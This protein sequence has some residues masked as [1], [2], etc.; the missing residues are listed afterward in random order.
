MGSNSIGQSN[1]TTPT[2]TFPA[3]GLYTVQLIASSHSTCSDTSEVQVTI[4]EPL[5]MSISHTDSLCIDYTFDFFATVSGPSNATY[6]W[7]FG[8]HANP[9]TSSDLSVQGLSYTQSGTMPVYFIGQ[10]DNC[11][12]TV[13]SNVRIFEHASIDFMFINTLQCAPSLAQ[14]VNLSQSDVPIQYVWDFGDGN[15]STAVNPNHIYLSPGN[16][17]VGLTLNQLYGCMDT[18]YLMKQDLVT[19][20]P[21]PTAGFMV[22]PEK[23]DVCQ[24][25]VSF[26]DQSIGATNY[27]YVFDN[28]EYTSNLASFSH[29]YVNAGSDYPIQIVSNQYGCRDTARRTVMVEPFSIYIPNTFIPDQNNRNELFIPVTSFDVVA[30]DL[31]IYNRWGEAIFQT[32]DPLQAWDGQLNGVM[33]QD[34]L[35]SYKLKFR[36]CD[37]PYIWQ[38]VDGFVTLIR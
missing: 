28:R 10:Y 26:F 27:Q 24:N 16:Y 8:I 17:S 29:D 7:D 34:G 11:T 4:N 13:S 35:Y 20:N 23:V 22:N 15:T 25:V 38:Q 3:P 32:N 33:C 30:W 9:N 18:L 21:S 31:G 14:F 19:V 5:V 37:K 36:S 2:F 12:D 1:A 6:Q